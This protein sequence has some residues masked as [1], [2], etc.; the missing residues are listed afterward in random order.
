MSPNHIAY[1]TRS[2]VHFHTISCYTSIK[3]HTSAPYIFH[4]M[5]YLHCIVPPGSSTLFAW[6]IQ[7]K[8]SPFARGYSQV[9]QRVCKFRP[10][11]PELRVCLQ[12][13]VRCAASRMEPVTTHWS[14]SL[15]CH[16]RTVHSIPKP[17]VAHYF[18]P[19]LTHTEGSAISCVY[20]HGSGPTLGGTTALYLGLQ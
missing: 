12:G 13:K 6:C 15:Q 17:G 14:L 9:G 19:T 3:F 5:L 10:S 16:T 4:T 8:T 18:R 7:H 11:F 2:Y 20:R 1:S